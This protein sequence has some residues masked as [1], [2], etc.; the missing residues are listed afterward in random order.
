[1][2]PDEK[3]TAAAERAAEFVLA[4]LRDDNGRLI[5][6]WRAGSAAGDGQLE[7]YAFLAWGLVE[8]YETTFDPRWLRE[9]L[10]LVAV[11]NKH[12]ADTERGGYF[13][14]ADDAEQLL[15][16]AKDAYDGA[17]P[18]GN[19]AA[20]WVL[21]R[22]ARMTGNADLERDARRTMEAF[23]E[24]LAKA[25]TAHAQMLIG[26]DLLLGPSREVVLVGTPGDEDFEALRSEVHLALGARTVVLHQSEG[27]AG[28]APFTTDMK[29]VDGK[30]A[31]YVCENFAC[32]RPV[33][34]ANELRALLES[35]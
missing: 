11:L 26:L 22:L 8:L 13:Q 6:C 15:V 18:S 29:K 34:T 35:E 20:A 9:S 28:I 3:A 21:T 17:I 12:F 16:R 23:G 19:G 2:L 5:K 30:A 25:P 24:T 31:A 32:K 33:T 7:D 4:N 10:A 14:V 1:L 27:I